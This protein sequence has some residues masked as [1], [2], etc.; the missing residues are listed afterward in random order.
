MLRLVRSNKIVQILTFSLHIVKIIQLFDV[1]IIGDHDEGVVCPSTTRSTSRGDPEMRVLIRA[2]LAFSI[3]LLAMPASAY[4][5]YMVGHPCVTTQRMNIY[6]VVTST[7]PGRCPASA[8]VNHMADAMRH[9]EWVA[10]PEK[11]S[12]FESGG[13]G[14]GAAAGADGAAGAGAG[15]H[16]GHGGHGGGGHG[17]GH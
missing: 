17:H 10:E 6:S 7:D 13:V 9:P 8:F 1:L 11:G 4:A 14:A 16:G 3:F 15:G 12:F 2:A 5:A